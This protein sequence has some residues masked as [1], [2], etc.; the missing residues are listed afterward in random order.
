MLSILIRQ[1]YSDFGAHEAHTFCFCSHTANLAL[2]KPTAQSSTYDHRAKSEN[3]VDG[4]RNTNWGNIGWC[5]HTNWNNP[6]WWRVDLGSN[7]VPLSD[8]FVI[9]RLTGHL[10][11]SEDLKITLGKYA[12][13]SELKLKHR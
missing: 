6:A 11:R 4:V 9:N 7:H 8:V 10:E 2:K 3:A 1:F 12:K 13:H 5:T